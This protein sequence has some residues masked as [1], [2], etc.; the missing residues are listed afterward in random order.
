MLLRLRCGRVLQYAV[1][2]VPLGSAIEPAHT[3]V[4][5]HGWPSAWVCVWGGGGAWCTKCGVARGT[6]L[7]GL[8]H[9]AQTRT[10]NRHLLLCTPAYAEAMRTYILT[11]QW[12]VPALL[13]CPPG[14]RHEAAFL[15]P[16]ARDNQLRV[17]AVN[18]PGVGESTYN[19]GAQ[20]GPAHG[21]AG[22]P[23]NPGIQ[24]QCSSMQALAVRL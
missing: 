5:H 3:V 11:M 16:H 15:E 10:S 12:A 13:L 4:Y 6:G 24:G 1:Y 23:C 9:H 8:C 19:P 22:R 18:R 21:E 14:C 2:G 17:V 20:H 7:S